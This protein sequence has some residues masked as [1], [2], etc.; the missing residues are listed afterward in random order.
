VK[1]TFVSY[2]LLQMFFFVAIAVVNIYFSMMIGNKQFRFKKC[3]WFH[4]SEFFG[5]LKN[6]LCNSKKA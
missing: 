3:Y 4:E 6:K 2:S 5:I 1:I